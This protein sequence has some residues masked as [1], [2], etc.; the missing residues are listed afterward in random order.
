M[1]RIRSSTDGVG[2]VGINGHLKKCNVDTIETEG[3]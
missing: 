2:A 3:R 1:R